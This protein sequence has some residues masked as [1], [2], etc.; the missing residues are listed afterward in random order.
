[1][2]EGVEWVQET[3]TRFNIPALARFGV[4]AE[5]LPELIKKAAGASSMKGN[6]I[7]LTAEEL[8]VILVKA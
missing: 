4:T 8:R 3:C 2:L 7:Q 5:V 1:A 6:P